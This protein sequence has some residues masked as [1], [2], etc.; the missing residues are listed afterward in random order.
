MALLESKSKD[1]AHTLV[2]D[3][4]PRARNRYRLDG[5]PVVGTTTFLKAA[6]P[7]PEALIS[8]RSGKAAEYT[9]D[10]LASMGEV[11]ESLRE[12]TIKEAK[13][14]W[15]KDAQDAA[16][17]GTIVHE[18]AELSS[19]GKHEDSVKLL[20]KHEGT[21][22]WN[23]IL[24]AVQKVDEFLAQTKDEILLTEAMVA[25]PK[26]GYAGRFDRLVKRDGKVIISDFKTSKAFYLEQFIQ[27]AAYSIAIKEWLDIDVTGFEVIRFG[28]QGGTFE[29]LLIS[30]PSEIEEL[31]AAA[32]RCKAVYDS[33]RR[34]E[35]DERF[36]R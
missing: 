36:K 11:T 26:H 6:Y 34:W 25:S 22:F 17:I 3:D 7:T 33:I 4:R 8:W 21:E 19:L 31:K 16:G 12:A 27:D 29:Q 14:A 18:Y 32:I 23:E 35:Q 1:G 20:S 15:R 24:N 10:K 9:W 5:E 30:E 2:Y 28:K 13:Q